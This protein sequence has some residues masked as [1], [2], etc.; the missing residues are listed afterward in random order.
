[1]DGFRCLDRQV[2]GG[3]RQGTV[4][5]LNER[6]DYG[7]PQRTLSPV[8]RSRQGRQRHCSWADN[9]QVA[10]GGTYQGAR[11]PGASKNK[12]QGRTEGPSPDR[13]QRRPE[14]RAEGL[15]VKVK[16]SEVQQEPGGGLT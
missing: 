16:C 12:S 1:M 2:L 14:G 9:G 10:P 15:E 7:S 5:C 6:G 13:E 11:A 4:M 8:C 3:Q